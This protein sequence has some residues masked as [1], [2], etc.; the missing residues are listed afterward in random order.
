[1]AIIDMYGFEHMPVGRAMNNGTVFTQEGYPLFNPSP[2][3]SS[4]NT[5]VRNGTTRLRC[6]WNYAGGGGGSTGRNAYLLQR[7]ARQIFKNPAV[8]KV[9]V[10][11]MRIF[12]DDAFKSYQGSFASPYMLTIANQPVDT[13]MLKTLPAGE[14]FIEYVFDFATGWIE[15]YANGDRFSSIQI[16]GLVLEHSIYFG[17][18]NYY[19]TSIP[20]LV[21]VD[22]SDIYITYDTGD[23]SP[24]G[25]LGP[26]RVRPLDLAPVDIPD[27]WAFADDDIEALTQPYALYPATTP[28]SFQGHALIPQRLTEFP[29]LNVV[30]LTTS[31]SITT[32]QLAIM[33]LPASTYSPFQIASDNVPITMTA[34]FANRKK[35]SAYGLGSGPVNT[36]FF[37]DWTFEGSND[38]TTWD[39]LDSRTG[40]QPYFNTAGMRYA[41][42]KLDPAKINWYTQYRLRVTKS[43]R[44]PS[45]GRSVNISHFQLIGDPADARENCK[46]DVIDRPFEVS[47]GYLNYG[48]DFPVL[49]TSTDGAEGKFGFNVPEFG[50]GDIMAVQVGL[51]GRR[52]QASEEHLIVKTVSAAGESAPANIA[53]DPHGGNHAIIQHM[54]KNHAGEKWSKADLESLKVVV[55]SKSGAY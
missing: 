28:V 16:V 50:P 36:G 17:P 8:N 11:G 27:Q 7:T 32:N 33:L 35:V 1:M 21:T 54:T 29:L 12:I 22:V 13:D 9:G 52:D 26:V 3:F 39:A 44:A 41:A 15:V 45:D 4:W 5:A 24:S 20:A 37:M 49:R 46:N 48:K 51:S 6:T 14:H 40:M 23:G 18:V 42:F 43:V 34:K 31:Q 55:K 38:G 19:Q 53:L 30:D 25:R 2:T 47:A 10:I